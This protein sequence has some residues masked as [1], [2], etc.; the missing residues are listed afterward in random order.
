LG[1][2]GGCGGVGS[3]LSLSSIFYIFSSFIVFFKIAFEDVFEKT[4]FVKFKIS[5][6]FK[7]NIDETHSKQPKINRKIHPSLWISIENL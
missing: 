6:N 1:G 2:A 5:N 7:Q 3:V 4:V